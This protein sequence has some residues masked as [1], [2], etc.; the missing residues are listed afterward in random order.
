MK[1]PT[2]LCGNYEINHEIRIPS[3]NNQY[4][5]ESKFFFRGSLISGFSWVLE[6]LGGFFGFGMRN[7]TLT[8][9][10]RGK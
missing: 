8:E 3:L 6:D 4:F 1:F 2:Q 7:K 5:M 10:N 9:C